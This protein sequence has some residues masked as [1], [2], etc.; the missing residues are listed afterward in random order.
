MLGVAMW[1][2]AATA[3]RG[4][5][6]GG[7]PSPRSSSSAFMTTSRHFHQMIRTTR[8]RDTR[9][10]Q[11][12]TWSALSPLV[13]PDL[14]EGI[15]RRLVEEHLLDPLRFWLPVPPPSVSAA[16][17][18]FSTRDRFL[19]LRR[20]WRGPTWINA[21][22]LGVAGPREARLSRRGRRTGQ[23]NRWRRFA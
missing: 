14:P 18:K 16:D 15:G 10:R 4:F 5:R 17:N 9:R 21:A 12:I 23:A 19:F 2:F 13:L 1:R 7:L 3:C 8:H 20:Y 11:P 6:R 22:W